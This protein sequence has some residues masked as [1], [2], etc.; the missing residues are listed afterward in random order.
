[1]A[2][3]TLFSFAVMLGCFVAGGCIVDV[4]H[5][6]TVYSCAESQACPTGLECINDIC[7]SNASIDAG[8]VDNDSGPTAAPL[9]GGDVFFYSFDDEGSP[10][11]IQDRS[12]NG[13]DAHRSRALLVDGKYG[14]AREFDDVEDDNE[15]RLIDNPALFL[16]NILTIEAYVNH[17]VGQQRA[18]IYGD[19]DPEEAQDSVEYALLIDAMDR[20]EFKTNTGCGT[21]PISFVSDGTIGVGAFHHVAVSWDGATIRFYIDGVLSGEHA[22]SAEPCQSL[23]PRRYLVGRRSDDLEEWNGIIDELK[24]SRVAK[25]ARDISASMDHDSAALDVGVC[26]DR[27]LEA[28]ACMADEEC[29][30]STCA[31]EAEGAACD[32]GSVCNSE[33]ACLVSGG[34]TANG[35]LALYEFNEGAGIAVGDTSGVAPPLDLAIDTEAAVTWGAGTLQIN[36]E[37][38]IASPVAAL[39]IETAVEASDELTVEAW[40]AAANT[41]QSGPARI[42]SMSPDTSVRNF[43]LGQERT[44]YSTRLRASA[45]SDGRPVASTPPNQVA[46][47]ALTHL[48][49][50]R[51]QAGERRMYVD[52]VL[53]SSSTIGGSLGNWSAYPLGIANEAVG[54]RLWLGTFHLVAVYGRALTDSEVSANFA[55]GAGE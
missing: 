49:V 33:G 17:A 43:T 24:L 34:R 38:I 35:L 1:M 4:N 27:L 10:S 6:N 32:Q 41:T 36:A 50:T 54:G 40:V 26:G 30:T 2:S 15:L 21:A 42:V 48:V 20:V 29:C 14:Q 25:T 37:V 5:G 16:E 55:A 28:E 8:P 52:G 18:V 22:Q 7:V 19:E 44:A 3:R 46:T 47:D 23:S 13:L 31:F 12:G 39:K 51:S 9:V 11:L 45:N 53:R